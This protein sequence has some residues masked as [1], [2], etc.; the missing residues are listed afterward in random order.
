MFAPVENGRTLQDSTAHYTLPLNDI[1][2]NSVLK[3]LSIEV[4]SKR[5]VCQ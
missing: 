2:K 3:A 1:Q 4:A 5:K